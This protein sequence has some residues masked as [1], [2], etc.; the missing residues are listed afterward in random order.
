MNK[1]QENLLPAR[2]D[3]IEDLNP[4]SP[5][6]KTASIDWVRWVFLATLVVFL[7]CVGYST[8]YRT[9]W[10]EI[11]RTDYTV[12]SIAGQAVL[13]GTNIY[14]AHNQRGWY[15]VYPPFFAIFLPIFAKLSL[16]VGS[17]LWY[18]LSLSGVIS[19]LY[20]SVKLARQ[21]YPSLGGEND[22][23]TLYEVP[24][25]LASP[26]LVSGL[27]RC[28]ASEFM[29]WLVIAAVYCWWRGRHVL[30]GLSLAAAAL[31]K[32]FPIALLAYFVW[33]RQWRFLGAFGLGLLLGGL[34]LPAAVFGWQQNLDYWQE[35]GK[36]VAGPALSVHEG[37]V[38]N[39]KAGELYTQLL[40]VNKPRNQSIESV[41]LTLE[42]PPAL[43]KPLLVGIAFL[44]LAAMAWLARKPAAMTQLLAVSA[45]VTW[46]LLIPPISESHY[47]GLMLLPLTLLMAIALGETNR[48]SRHLA[49]WPLV[50]FFV[51]SL[52]SNLD[53]DMH[54]YR[55]LAWAT[56]AVWV[57]LMVLIYRYNK[58]P[59]TLHSEA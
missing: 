34:V 26:W 47:F 28:Q 1:P 14:E 36:L 12:Y 32:A 49:L 54:M 45:F 2:A 41:L 52:W 58:D 46:N 19:A 13:D 20:L 44:M 43:A 38:E 42:V 37:P 25:L 16:A 23:W 22:A 31:I 30:G 10:N 59:S 9:A 15:Y 53:K 18:F 57:S 56:L 17:G 24:A 39:N 8:I 11:E 35:W 6:H 50:I 48:I 5:P 21:A 4:N 29:I 27:L 33:R 51:T 7:V 40:D 3:V 55:F